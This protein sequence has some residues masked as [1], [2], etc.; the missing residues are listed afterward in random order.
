MDYHNPRIAAFRFRVRCVLTL[1]HALQLALAW[2][3][4]WA[5]AVV[6]LRVSGA[7]FSFWW[8]LLGYLPAVAA[9]VWLANRCVPSRAVAMA[10]L[11]RGGR[12]GGLL[13]TAG[14][15]EIHGW[16]DRISNVPQPAVRFDARRH[17][18]LLLCAIAFLA[19]AAMTPD[20][21]L[22]S[23]E[24]EPLQLGQQ[25]QELSAK[26]EALKQEQILPPEKA[27]V[28]EKNLEQ[29]RQ[30][31]AGNDPA[32]TLEAL[33]HLEQSFSQAAEEAAE[34]AQK[35][36]Q[37]AGRLEELADALQEA[38]DQMDPQQFSEAMSELNE[39]AQQAAADNASLLDGLDGDLLDSLQQGNLSP[40]QLSQLSGALKNLKACDLKQI[41]NLIKARLIDASE[42]EKIEAAGE[43]DGEALAAILVQC[44]NA[45][46]IANAINGDGLPGRGGVSRGRGDAAITWKDEASK[47]D[48]AF[49]EQTLTPAAIASL[50]ESRLLGTSVGDPKSPQPG[51]AS[52]GGALESAQAG[53]GS[54]RTQLILPEHDKTVQKYFNREKK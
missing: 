47:E 54:A 9:A 14:E 40:E 8:G 6:A 2:T 27:Q 20:K 38:Q 24:T 3:M 45:G 32:K 43:C 7:D 22:P 46:Q 5:A 52:A 1:R 41:E 19:V 42:L 13:M 4:I 49:K 29:I 18:L 10:I 33:D 12:L 53:G 37:A 23:A 21:Y 11:D 31:A 28:L 17:C 48:I 35:R 50:K 34:S 30:E 36:A 44:E 16:R 15:M 39:L 51:G 25:M 26:V